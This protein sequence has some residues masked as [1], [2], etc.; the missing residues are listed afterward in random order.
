MS[1]T[2]NEL[3][4]L[5]VKQVWKDVAARIVQS[6][7]VTLAFVELSPNSVVPLHHHINEQVGFVITGSL[8]F[9]VDGETQKRGPGDT[10]RILTDMP[11]EVQA[12]PD[13]AVVAEV[14]SPVRQDWSEFP[15]GEARTPLWPAQL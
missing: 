10:W 2:F 4:A 8:L 14:Y 9:T 3:A 11:H 7:L 13:G 15:D 6:E 1:A 12:G 5:P